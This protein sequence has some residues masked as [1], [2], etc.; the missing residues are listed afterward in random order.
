MNDQDK[1]ASERWFASLNNSHLSR[2][3][4]LNRGASQE[5][6][7]AACE[8]KQREIDELK[9]IV[10]LAAEAGCYTEY[11]DACSFAKKTLKKLNEKLEVR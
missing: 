8:Y 1:E 6:W 9:G 3:I 2:V 10:M 7:Q 5:A 4:K 11:E